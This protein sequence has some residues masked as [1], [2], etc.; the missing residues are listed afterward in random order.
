MT[1][2]ENIYIEL[3]S[4][5]H[6]YEFPCGTSTANIKLGLE[7]MQSFRLQRNAEVISVSLGIL[8]H[9]SEPRQCLTNR[10]LLKHF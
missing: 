5:F 2:S 7:G 8:V 6:W 4:T 3:L 9:C 1:Q 10:I